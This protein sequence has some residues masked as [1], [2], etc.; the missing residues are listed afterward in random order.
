MAYANSTHDF[1]QLKRPASAISRHRASSGAH[2][3]ARMESTAS[4]NTS[5]Q[6][7]RSRSGT[8]PQPHRKETNSI[9]KENDEV[10]G[11]AHATGSSSSAQIRVE[12]SHDIIL[13][14]VLDKAIKLSEFKWENA[15][16]IL[17]AATENARAQKAG[18][19]ERMKETEYRFRNIRQVGDC[20]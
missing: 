9:E 17:E 11:G 19:Y 18:A 16:K 1:L 2:T 15:I 4:S 7:D 8:R 13:A 10:S 20:N 14:D 6:R 5:V 3:A 12:S